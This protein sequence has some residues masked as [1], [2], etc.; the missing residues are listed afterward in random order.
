MRVREMERRACCGGEVST[1]HDRICCSHDSSHPVHLNGPYFYLYLLPRPSSPTAPCIH[2]THTPIS[3]L[4]TSVE[5]GWLGFAGNLVGGLAALVFGFL[6]DKW[7]LRLKRSVVILFL[8][9]TISMAGLALFLQFAVPHA[10]HSNSSSSSSSSS[11]AHNMTP[12][13][14]DE[15]GAV[16][17]MDSA[18]LLSARQVLSAHPLVGPAVPMAS[19]LSPFPSPPLAL[20]P[21]Q[22]CNNNNTGTNGTTPNQR[23]TPPPM[24]WWTTLVLVLIA[25]SSSTAVGAVAMEWAVDLTFPLSE[26]VSAGIL[27]FVFNLF[28]GIF[29]F[30]GDVLTGWVI[31][32]T[33][34]AVVG[35]ATV[36]L[37][38][39]QD[40]NRRQMVH[41]GPPSGTSGPLV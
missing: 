23:R 12:R 10:H 36:A 27:T 17:A 9:T 8:I 11:G 25:G 19:P 40:E 41:R 5:V 18:T 34:V 4:F 3:Q 37:L 35:A 1:K 38:F 29:A 13:M 32:Y 22:Y 33:T 20:P 24:V 21:S 16:G 30:L 15:R 6:V 26:A 31:T 14:G 39:V 2:S 28:V 7:G